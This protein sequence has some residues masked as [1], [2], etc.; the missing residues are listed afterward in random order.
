MALLSVAGQGLRGSGYTAFDGTAPAGDAA[1]HAAVAA[2]YAHVT[3]PLRRLGDRYAAEV[4]V[5]H[6]TGRPVPGWVRDRL[7]QLPKVLEAAGQRAAA[8]DRAVVDLLEAAELAPDVGAELDAVVLGVRNGHI[9]VQVLD[10]PVVAD[11]GLPA[12][13]PAPADGAR[14]T[15]RVE[16]VDVTA[17]ST[18]FAL[19]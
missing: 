10:P 1:R 11:A 14:V 8:V 12:E 3:A 2:P 5:A 7:A 18:R 17:R 13:A 6:S 9:R 19:V 4:A 16:A 15:V